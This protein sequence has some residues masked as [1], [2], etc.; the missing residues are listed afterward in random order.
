MK[1]LITVIAVLFLFGGVTAQ[2]TFTYKWDAP[3][4]N[5]DGTPITNLAGY[6]VYINGELVRTTDELEV[7][8]EVPES[9]EIKVTA[10]KLSGV[11]SEP[12]VTDN[13]IPK[14]VGGCSIR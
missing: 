6:K 7:Q 8:L 13:K 12:C 9:Y 5:A 4:E 2:E 11:E 14:K 10:Y 3:T 1:L